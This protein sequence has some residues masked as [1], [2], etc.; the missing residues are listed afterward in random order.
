[1]KDV[2]LNISEDQTSSESSSIL[3]F[4]ITFSEQSLALHAATIN[5]EIRFQIKLNPIKTI[6]RGGKNTFYLTLVIPPSLSGALM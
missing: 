5:F 2:K 6:L 1:M 3:L 4:N